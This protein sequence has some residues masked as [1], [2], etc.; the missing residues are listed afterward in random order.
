[1]PLSIVY[2]SDSN[3]VS[4]A[5]H[6][7]FHY[8][9]HLRPPEF[10]THVFFR[11]SNT[12]M[13]QALDVRGIGYTQSDGFSTR[14]IR[15]TWRCDDL[16]SFATAFRRIRRELRQVLERERADIVHSISYPT[17]LYTA[18]AARAAGVPQV[19][20]EHNIKRI[21]RFNA[22]I[23]RWVAGSCRRVVGPSDAVTHAIGQAGISL[24]RLQTVYNG[25]DLSRFVRSQDERER[26]RQE[27]GLSGTEM[28]V[29][30][31]GQLLPYK[32]H[33]TLIEAAPA[34]LAAHP[35][36]RFFIVGAL[37]N[38][39]YE[40]DLRAAIRAAALEDR[41]VF[42]GWRSDVHA[43]VS[44]MDV[45]IVATLTPE[46][47]ALSLMEAMALGC[48]LIA[49]R[50]GGTAE[51]VLDR[52]TGLLFPPGDS[53]ALATL[54]NEVFTNAALRERLAMAGR[55][56]MVERFSLQRHLDQMVAMYRSSVA[57]AAV[58]PEMTPSRLV[59]GGDAVTG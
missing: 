42:T 58:P 45:S 19:W 4:G 6:V 17:A 20:H 40:Q 18:F 47:A 59:D 33:R 46:P 16:W 32:G 26:M 14:T 24:P 37:E 15:T 22:P 5:E 10:K 34:I 21:H 30:L 55:R 44:A 48:P 8:L 27:L 3:T 23:Y 49:S 36:T 43:I 1:M 52:E 25:I 51:I 41:F 38:P 29:G 57:E 7:L 2:V 12:R 54:V 56:R 28:A 35:R 50:T 11:A 39:P 9:D 53:E 13:R 31:V